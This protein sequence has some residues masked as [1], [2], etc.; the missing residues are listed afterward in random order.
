M[1][2]PNKP[3]WTFETAMKRLEEIIR[4]LE[5]A[6]LPLHEA[7]EQYKESLHLVRFCREM[8]D[9]AELEIEQLLQ[10]PPQA[11]VSAQPGEEA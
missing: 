9:K 5:S 7:I 8:L 10:E 11:A 2:E 6:E 4:R 1:T 3:D